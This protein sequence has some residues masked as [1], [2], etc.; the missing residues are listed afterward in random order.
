[1]DGTHVLTCPVFNTF[2]IVGKKFTLLIIRNMMAL[3]QIKF[4]E[5]FNSIEGIN[6]KTLSIRLREMTEDGLIVKEVVQTDPVVIEY[7]LTE[8]GLALRPIIAAMAEFSMTYYADTVFEDKKP[9]TIKDIEQYRPKVNI[10]PRKSKKMFSNK[11][12]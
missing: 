8:K 2:N 7:H 3:R 5:F 10:T 9:R 12:N 1:M 6:A 11:N 4:N